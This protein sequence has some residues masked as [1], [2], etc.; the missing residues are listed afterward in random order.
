MKHVIFLGSETSNPID[1]NLQAHFIQMAYRACKP[2]DLD[3]YPGVNIQNFSDCLALDPS[4][5]HRDILHLSCHGDMAGVYIADVNDKPGVHVSTAQLATVLENHQFN[6][7]YIDACQSWQV[8]KD[9][10]EKKH[11]NIKLVIGHLE[12][13]NVTASYLGARSFHN[14]LA[15]GGTYQEAIDT[16]RETIH[17]LGNA[18]QLYVAHEQGWTSQ[19]LLPKPPEVIARFANNKDIGPDEEGDYHIE[20][21]ATGFELVDYERCV[22]S[23][24]SDDQTLIGGAYTTVESGVP[25]PDANNGAFGTFWTNDYKAKQ[26]DQEIWEVDGDFRV[27]MSY[28]YDGEYDIIKSSLKTALSRYYDSV[29]FKIDPDRRSAAKRAIEGLR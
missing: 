1:V 11:L 20:F 25:S 4:P 28:F 17:L 14:V 23:F 24:F 8:V 9:L 15:K 18:N 10:F 19:T 5:P 29:C 7:V 22:V 3:P 13:V 2:V 16:L 27:F 26:R 6:V 21:G 12:D